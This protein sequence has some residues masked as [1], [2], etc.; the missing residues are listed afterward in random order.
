MRCRRSSA[1]IAGII[2]LLV[3]LDRRK[4]SRPVADRRRRTSRASW[5]DRLCDNLGTTERKAAMNRRGFFVVEQHSSRSARSLP[6]AP[7]AG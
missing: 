4:R 2:A 7:A 3:M 1:R 6:A 5:T